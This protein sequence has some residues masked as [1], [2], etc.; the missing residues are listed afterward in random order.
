VATF[1]SV[2]MVIFMA[3]PKAARA[4]FSPDAPEVDPGSM[5]SA[6]TLLVGG[7]MTMTGRNRR[8]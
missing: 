5:A 1:A 6:P 2:L 3:K 4:D 8:A 7:V